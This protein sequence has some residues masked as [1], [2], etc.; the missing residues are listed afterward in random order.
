MLEQLRPEGWLRPAPLGK[1]LPG[2]VGEV[3][4]DARSGCHRMLILPMW[5]R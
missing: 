4:T 3:M 1:P 2:T 5:R